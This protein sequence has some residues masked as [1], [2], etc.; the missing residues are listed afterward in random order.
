MKKDK[1]NGLIYIFLGIALIFISLLAIVEQTSFI[2]RIF[3]VLGIILIINGLMQLFNYFRKNKDNI[4]INLIIFNIIGG[5]TIIIFSDIPAYVLTIIFALYLSINGI[6]RFISYL[7]YKKDKVPERIYLLI[8][9]IFLIFNGISILLSPIINSD[10]TIILIA[11]Y[12]FLLG[13]MYIRDGIMVVIPRK[14]KDEF[15]RKIR[16][17]LPV[18]LA[19]LVP[20]SMLNYINDKLKVDADSLELQFDDDEVDLEIFIHVSPDGFGKMGHCD[21]YFD[22]EVISY[23]NYDYSSIRLFETIGD[24]VL[25]TTNKEEYLPF[26]IKEDNKVIFGYGLK[27][28]SRQKERVKQSIQRV[29]SNTYPWFPP[30]YYDSKNLEEYA[31]RLYVTTKAKFYKFEQSKFKTYFLLGTNCVLLAEQIVGK[32]GLDIINLNGVVA[33]GS[34]QDFLEKEYQRENSLVVSKNVYYKNNTVH[35]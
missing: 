25:F 6:V 27:L 7:N 34:Y 30:S 4:K 3:D 19:A 31:S 24:G 14:K 2:I 18:F 16:I 12:G 1:Y 20:N 21:I 33:P 32:S 22:G 23:G 8:F 17:T 28:T 35:K 9:S 26:C 15:K 29:K 11:I 13:T 10:F 5:I